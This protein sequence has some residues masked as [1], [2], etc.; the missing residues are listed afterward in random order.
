MVSVAAESGA[1]IILMHI[2]GE[3]RTMQQGPS[4]KDVMSE[5]AAELKESIAVCEK[6]GVAPEKIIIDPG[7]GFGKTAEHNVEIIRR[8]AELKALKKPIL[9]GPSRKSFIGE[10]LGIK[11]PAERL[12]GT[13]AAVAAAIISGADI[14]RVHDVGQISQ[15]CRLIDAIFRQ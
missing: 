12:M 9:I 13:A 2:R 3:P 6:N 10:L 4:Y 15:V 7:I 5:I 1:A 11:A 8:L 14:V